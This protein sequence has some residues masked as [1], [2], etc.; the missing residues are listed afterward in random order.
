MLGIARGEGEAFAHL[1]RRHSPWAFRLLYRLLGQRALAEDVL[2]SCFVQI[3]EKPS[4]WVPRA[5]FRTWLYRVLHNRCLDHFR[6]HQRQSNLDPHVL[7][8]TEAIDDTLDD[9]QQA[10]VGLVQPGIEQGVMQRVDVQTALQS[11]PERQRAAIVLVYFEDLSQIE[12]AGIMGVSVGALESLL[13][14]ARVQLSRQLAAH[15]H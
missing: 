4:A 2:Q 5:Q 11:L 9:A 1:V 7:D 6:R 12:V 8:A 10:A 13:S 14:R 15:R 3:W